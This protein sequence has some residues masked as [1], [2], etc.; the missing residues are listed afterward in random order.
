MLSIIKF[1]TITF[2]Q[3][4]ALGIMTNVISSKSNSISKNMRISHISQTQKEFLGNNQF[5]YKSLSEKLR[6]PAITFAV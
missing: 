4:L 5:F 3:I 1:L 2:A 6:F